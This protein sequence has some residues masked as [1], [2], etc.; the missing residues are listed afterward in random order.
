MVYNKRQEGKGCPQ[1][2]ENA[3]GCLV[4]G[5]GVFCEERDYGIYSGVAFDNGNRG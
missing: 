4:E 5:R 3:G 1:K 2:H